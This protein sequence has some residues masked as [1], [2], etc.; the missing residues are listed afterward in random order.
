MDIALLNGIGREPVTS[1]LPA[2]TDARD[3]P[4]FDALQAEIGKLSNPGVDGSTDWAQVAQLASVLLVSR[5]KDLLVAGYLHAALVQQSGLDGLNAGLQVIGDM[6]ENFW[7]DMFPPLARPRA[8]R[9]A[10]QWLLDRTELV[11]G[12]QRWYEL[13]PQ[14]EPLMTGLQA[15]ARRLDALLR[16]KDEEAPSLRSLLALIDRIPVAETAAP[17]APQMA[18]GGG[19]VET[20]SASALAASA[21]STSF[22]P[23]PLAGDPSQALTQVTEHLNPLADALMAAD[24][25]DA[26][27]YRVSRFANWCNLEALPPAAN[28]LTQIGPPITQVLDA[29]ERLHQE[30]ADGQDAIRFAEA[31]LPAF[32]L[33]LDLQSLCATGLARLG[34]A[35]NAARREV[36]RATRDLLDRLPGL[37]GLSFSNGM[38]FANGRTLDWIAGLGSAEG[39]S[40]ERGAQTAADRLAPAT[41][42]ARALAAEG[43]LEAAVSLLQRAIDDAADPP[44]QLRARIRMCQL[45]STHRE[46]RVPLPFAHVIVEQL[47]RHDLER[48]D[49]GLAVEGWIAAH[50]VLSQESANP[51]ER[52]AALAAI[53]RLDAARAIALTT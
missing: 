13:D 31:Q 25:Q 29:L 47:L 4:R 30:G 53:A 2:G 34:E 35:G 6:V 49:P 33:W 16:E 27:A 45:L 19:G 24:I 52:D 15:A 40:V 8:R 18:V 32:P 1:M 50:A 48:W 28:G 41:A 23:G 14:P 38:P 22:A 17:A 44:T 11:A 9:N 7:P 43:E 36:E 51:I 39:A 20:A 26:R 3:D 21:P 42:Q 37:V 46:G 10:I 12:E 5:G